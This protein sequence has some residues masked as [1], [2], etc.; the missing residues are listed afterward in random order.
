MRPRLKVLTAATVLT[1]LWA[2]DAF[3]RAIIRAVTG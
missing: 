1:F 2:D 3:I